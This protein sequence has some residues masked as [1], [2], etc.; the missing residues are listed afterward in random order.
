MDLGMRREKS[1]PLEDDMALRDIG[2]EDVVIIESK[3][4]ASTSQLKKQVSA[5]P[6]KAQPSQKSR[7]A[8]PSPK[9]EKVQ[10]PSK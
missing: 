2:D 9:K 3:N 10:P 8:K 5:W 7:W 4:Q 1:K 6:V